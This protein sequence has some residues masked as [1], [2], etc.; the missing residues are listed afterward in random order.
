MTV[1]ESQEKGGCRQS[2]VQAGIT[3]KED[4]TRMVG[5]GK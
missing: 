1:K 5:Y 2:T 4:S 3:N